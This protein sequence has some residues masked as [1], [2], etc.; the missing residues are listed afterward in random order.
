VEDPQLRTRF[1]AFDEAARTTGGTPP[2]REDA[3]AAREILA[4]IFPDPGPRRATVGV[5]ADVIQHAH[6]QSVGLGLAQ[7]WERI[8]RTLR[9]VAQSACM[10]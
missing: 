2:S 7:S 5:L 8:E 4:R 10:P 9:R 1:D 3:E 6:A